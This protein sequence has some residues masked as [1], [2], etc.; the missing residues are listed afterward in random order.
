MIYSNDL[1]CFEGLVC[2]S[3]GARTWKINTNK[4]KPMVQGTEMYWDKDISNTEHS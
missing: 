3:N 1:K 2:T 4:H